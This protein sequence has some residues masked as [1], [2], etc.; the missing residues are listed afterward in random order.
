MKKSDAIGAGEILEFSFIP[1]KTGGTYVTMQL[2]RAWETGAAKTL[3]FEIKI[4]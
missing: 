4:L 2:M 1:L 3:E